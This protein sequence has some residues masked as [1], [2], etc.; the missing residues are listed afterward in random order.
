M[1]ATSKALVLQEDSGS[2]KTYTRISKVLRSEL[3]K[4][5]TK[6]EKAFND[7]RYDD[8]LT[9]HR[10]TLILADG[11]SG[12]E[13]TAAEIRGIM[14]EVQEA[15]TRSEAAAKEF[16]EFKKRV[17]AAAASPRELYDEGKKIQWKYKGAEHVPWWKDLADILIRLDAED[18]SR[19]P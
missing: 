19:K 9:A 2:T 16:R 12:M 14:E 7:N 10:R 8:A 13:A 11:E 6:A 18:R 17:E 15:K 3:L 4:L 1:T 5:R